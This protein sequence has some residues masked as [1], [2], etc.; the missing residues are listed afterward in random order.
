MSTLQQI[1]Q[2]NPEW[3]LE[4]FVEVSNHLLPQFLPNAT[5]PQAHPPETVNPRLVRYYTTQGVVDRPQR[6]GREARYTYRHLLQLLIVRRLLP[7]GYSTTAIQPITIKANPDLE[8]LLQG[9]M[10]L[11]V[12]AA[13]PALAF[14]QSVQARTAPPAAPPAARSARSMPPP[15][16]PAPQ[17]STAESLV[18]PEWGSPVSRWRRVTVLPGLEVQV[19]EDFVPPSTPQE[20][21]NLLQLIAQML[22]PLFQAKRSAP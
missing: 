16:A 8:A 6:Q 18:A 19:R 11:T 22:K 13:N 20:L 2:A 15:A 14:L 9:G 17:R 7:E 21:E 5:D 3:D 12:A 10:Q 4:T 1:A